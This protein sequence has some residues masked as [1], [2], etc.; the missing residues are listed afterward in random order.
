[1]YNLFMKDPKKYNIRFLSRNFN[2]SLKRV[3]AILRLKGLEQS[4]EKVSFTVTLFS[5]LCVRA[6][7]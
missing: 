1:M 5:D 6:S 2:I 4:W 7:I 3:D